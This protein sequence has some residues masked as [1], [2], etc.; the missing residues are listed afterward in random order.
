MFV[1]KLSGIQNNI[2]ECHLSTMISKFTAIAMY[3][4]VL[5]SLLFIEI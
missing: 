3:I 1:L 4:L 2:T 5:Y